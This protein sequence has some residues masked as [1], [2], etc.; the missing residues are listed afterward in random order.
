MEETAA[1]L[2]VV[3]D[4]RED[5]DERATGRTGKARAMMSSQKEMR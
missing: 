1:C 4:F 3:G 5:A 2:K